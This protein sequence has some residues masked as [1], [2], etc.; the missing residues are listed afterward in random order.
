M[1]SGVVGRYRDA[2]PHAFRGIEF[3]EGAKLNA[4][5]PLC[6]NI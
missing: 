3:P 1:N 4:L 2:T 6:L 5:M